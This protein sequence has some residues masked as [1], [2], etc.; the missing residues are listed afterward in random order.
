M[1]SGQPR[2]GCAAQRSPE[3]ARK[4]PVRPR[5]V[6]SRLKSPQVLFG[7][8]WRIFGALAVRQGRPAELIRSTTV[9]RRFQSDLN[10]APEPR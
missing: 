5:L 2:A 7:H 9:G 6:F 1:T 10:F 8:R 3:E 4:T